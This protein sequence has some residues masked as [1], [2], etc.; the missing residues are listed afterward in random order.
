LGYSAYLGNL[1]TGRFAQRTIPAIVGGDYS[2]YLTAVGHQLVYVGQ[3]GTTAIAADLTGKP[4]VLGTTQFFAPSADLGRVWLIYDRRM[5]M[6]CGAYRS[7]AAGR[8]PRSRSPGETGWTRERSEGCCSKAPGR[9]PP[10]V[11]S[12]PCAQAAAVLTELDWHVRRRRAHRR[13]RHRLQDHD[14]QL[15]HIQRQRRIRVAWPRV[16]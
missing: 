3:N 2:P 1:G 8:G 12:R 15:S 11:D 6:S 16:T 4:R 10:A 9:H 13:L 7:L 5:P 14:N